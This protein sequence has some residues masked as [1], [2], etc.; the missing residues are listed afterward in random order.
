MHSVKAASD[1]R[2]PIC[3]DCSS[4][5][6]F[7]MTSVAEL[8]LLMSTEPIGLLSFQPYT[9]FPNYAFLCQL[10]RLDIL[11]FQPYILFRIFPE[12]FK[13]ESRGSNEIN[14]A[15]PEAHRRNQS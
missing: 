9:L 11:S 14:D 10:S 5:A 7:G 8:R 3:S 2:L 6:E 4:A 15:R 13:A 1:N 12:C